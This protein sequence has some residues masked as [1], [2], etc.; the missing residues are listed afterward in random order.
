MIA[1]DEAWQTA[2][3]C[4]LQEL[5]VHQLSKLRLAFDYHP[6]LN[7]SRWYEGRVRVCNHMM[8][9]A[10]LVVDSTMQERAWPRSVLEL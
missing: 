1:R 3:L 9:D 4:F 7:S 2:K 6:R 10:E 8:D 5:S